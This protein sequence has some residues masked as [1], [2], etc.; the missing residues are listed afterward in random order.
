MKEVTRTLANLV[1]QQQNKANSQNVDSYEKLNKR[2]D[3]EMKNV[4]DMI[5]DLPKDENKPMDETKFNARMDRLGREISLMK[6]KQNEL[7]ETFESSLSKQT[8]LGN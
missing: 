4:S 3:L 5:K 6:A 1:E 7:S 2:L 8:F